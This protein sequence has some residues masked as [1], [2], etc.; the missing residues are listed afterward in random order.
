MNLDAKVKEDEQN[1]MEDFCS[2]IETQL[3]PFSYPL[4]TARVPVNLRGKWR[5]LTM[6]ALMT[7]NTSID[8]FLYFPHPKTSFTEFTTL[9]DFTLSPQCLKCKVP[10]KIQYCYF[11]INPHL[12]SFLL[13]YRYA[14]MCHYLINAKKYDFSLIYKYSFFNLLTF[15]FF[16]NLPFFKIF[17]FD[18]KIE[19]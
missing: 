6:H 5:V 3:S 1:I 19:L 17:L 14:C 10:H 11:P 18:S 16:C 2:P 4:T 15:H 12:I 13:S 9:N 7:L 8:T